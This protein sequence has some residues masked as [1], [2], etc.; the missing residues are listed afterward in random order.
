[1]PI[2][3]PKTFNRRKSSVTAPE[4]DNDSAPP[5]QS[6]FRILERPPDA[7]KSFDGPDKLKRGVVRRPKTSPTQQARRQSYGAGSESSNRQAPSLPAAFVDHSL[8][9]RRGSGNTNSSGDAFSTNRFSYASTVPSSVDS[10]SQDDLP[11][12]PRDPQSFNYHGS[13]DSPLP[14]PADQYHKSSFSIRA[15]GRALSYGPKTTKAIGKENNAG[16]A[17]QT[18]H[19]TM[20]ESSYTSGSTATPPK[21]DLGGPDLGMGGSDFGDMFKRKSAI[22]EEKDLPPAAPPRSVRCRQSSLLIPWLTC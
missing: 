14:N 11:L 10:I 20:T 16:P 2:K 12:K 8:T 17:I 5:A 6:S 13:A 7:T 21:I 22:L 19:R 3:F 18:R 9:I 4:P 15:A 1:M